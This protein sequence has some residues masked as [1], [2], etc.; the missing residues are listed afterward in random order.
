M[1]SPVSFFFTDPDPVIRTALAGTTSL[2]DSALNRAGPQL[3]S[4]VIISSIAAV[5]S[6]K[7][8]PYTYTEKDWNTFSEGEVKRLGKESPGPQIY[9]AS[10]VGAERA[11]WKF[12]DEKKPSFAMTAVNPG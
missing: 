4:V 2:L 3:K 8:P 10:K 1:A 12:R 5:R 11:F 6:P 9:L 7:E